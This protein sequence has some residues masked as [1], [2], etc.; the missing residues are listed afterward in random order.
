MTTVLVTGASGALGKAV[1]ALLREQGFAHEASSVVAVNAPLRIVAASRQVE[2]E[3]GV[4]LDVRNRERVAEVI[5]SI[6][7]D[8]VLH[9]AAT[10][11]DSFEE[12]FATNVD[13]ARNI[14]D[15]VSA[16]GRATRV[17]LTGT[18]AEYGAVLPESNPVPVQ[19]P[20]TPVSLYGMTKAWQSMLGLY[21]AGRGVDVV[22]A[23]VFNLDGAGVS[24][25]LFVGRV[26][27][28]I[29]AIRQQKQ[30]R[31][32]I[33]FLGAIRDYV[34]LPVAARQVLAIASHGRSG[35]VYHVGSGKGITMRELLQRT[36]VKEGLDFSLVDED[37]THSNRTG[38]DVP[39]IYA[40]MSATFALMPG[41]EPATGTD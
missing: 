31:L 13:G 39:V 23:R 35:A 41:L 32:K 12:A 3:E 14:L 22:I 19:Q 2:G 21:Y 33:G 7:P 11:N 40:D 26:R 9:F 25:R 1:I 28:Q 6:Q 36:L 18:A 27:E 8:L 29:E 24:T 16:S 4:A 15:A 20:L 37:S 30:Q 5:R 38:Y 17:L 34:P 10:L